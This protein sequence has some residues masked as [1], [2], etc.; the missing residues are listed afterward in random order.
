MR[1]VSPLI[2]LVVGILMLVATWIFGLFLQALGG[3]LSGHD[4]PCFVCLVVPGAL[5]CAWALVSL[6]RRPPVK[7]ESDP[8]AARPAKLDTLVEAIMHVVCS[9]ECIRETAYADGYHRVQTGDGIRAF[10]VGVTRDG[11]FYHFVRDKA[12]EDAPAADAIAKKHASAAQSG[13][14]IAAWVGFGS[15]TDSR[16]GKGS[17]KI[18]AFYIDEQF[19]VAPQELEYVLSYS[20]TQRGIQFHDLFERNWAG[21]SRFCR[22]MKIDRHVDPD[23]AQSEI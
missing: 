11:A 17:V 10:A 19:Q 1:R 23:V 4:M 21:G 14:E 8:N 2:L 13:V 9:V 7:E 18:L 12:A 3:S 6:T 22:V 16:R 15:M 5:V 20:T